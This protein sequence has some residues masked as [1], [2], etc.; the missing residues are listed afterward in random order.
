V[1]VADPAAATIDCTNGDITAAPGSGTIQVS[2]DMEVG[3]ADCTASVRVTSA[4]AGAY[5]NCEANFTD[6]V[7][8]YAPADCAELTCEA[9]DG[10][11]P[12][13]FINCGSAEAPEEFD[14]SIQE[15]WSTD[16]ITQAY[17]T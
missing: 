12:D 8:I 15:S 9:Y 14:F 6:L 1:T 3:Q 10:D 5:E 17:Q 4:S 13:F 7:N 16:A 2:G 11:L